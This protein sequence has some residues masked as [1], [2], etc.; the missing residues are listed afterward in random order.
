MQ[1][2][3]LKFPH[4]FLTIHKLNC[5]MVCLQEQTSQYLLCNTLLLNNFTLQT[6]IFNSKYRY[7][8]LS[9]VGHQSLSV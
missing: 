7:L 4:V 5:Q 3:F 6:E 1:L 2:Y 9:I 8:Y